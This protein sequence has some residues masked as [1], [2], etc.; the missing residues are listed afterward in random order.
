[1]NKKIPGI[2]V[3]TFTL[4]TLFSALPVMADPTKGQKV[5]AKYIVIPP[6]EIQ[7]GEGRLTNGGIFLSKGRVETYRNNLLFIGNNPP[8]TVCAVLVGTINSYNTKTETLSMHWECIW[9][10][11]TEGSPDGFAGNIKLKFFEYDAIT[12][13]WIS[14]KMHAVLQGFGAYAGQ[15]LMLSYDGPKSRVSI[16]YCLKG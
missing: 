16:G 6:Y 14:Q 1:M 9:Y 7:D 4:I 10:I 3:A 12:H 13:D 2:L 8:L 5:P 11:S 15:T